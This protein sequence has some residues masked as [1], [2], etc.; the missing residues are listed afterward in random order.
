MPTQCL[1]SKWLH[2]MIR[3][4]CIWASTQWSQDAPAHEQLRLTTVIM[5]LASL[6]QGAS[7]RMIARM[8]GV[9]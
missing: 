9:P 7:L 3:G 4:R 8:V 5:H 2:S 1:C 6:Y